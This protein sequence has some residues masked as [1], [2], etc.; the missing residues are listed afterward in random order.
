MT[1]QLWQ[2][3]AALGYSGH[4]G[5]F[6][7]LLGSFS[8]ETQYHVATHSLYLIRSSLQDVAGE[9]VQVFSQEHTGF[10]TLSLS[11][12]LNFLSRGEVVFLSWIGVDFGDL[13]LSESFNSLKDW[14]LGT[15]TLAS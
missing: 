1:P 14:A 8:H 6:G 15:Q 13:S 12:S 4:I 3:F 9:E 5:A 7:G 11:L 10:L 2:L